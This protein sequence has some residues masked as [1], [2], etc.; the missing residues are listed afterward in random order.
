MIGAGMYRDPISLT[1]G[2]LKLSGN[3]VDTVL[4]AERSEWYILFFDVPHIPYTVHP[5][6]VK[7]KENPARSNTLSYEW[8]TASKTENRLRLSV[9][10]NTSDT[11]RLIRICLMGDE[12]AKTDGQFLYVTQYPKEK[13]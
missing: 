13:D 10:E 1:T 9:A 12:K 5:D 3:A 8:L 7:L 4:T 11:A 2:N 6:D